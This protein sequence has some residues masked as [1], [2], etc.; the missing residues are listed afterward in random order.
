M[1][2]FRS[3]YQWQTKES[4]KA[5]HSCA[6]PACQENGEYKA[7]I[8]GVV[9]KYQYFCLMHIRQFNKDWNYFEGMSDGQVEREMERN[10]LGGQTWPMGL[11]NAAKR[12]NF[13]PEKIKDPFDLFADDE[14]ETKAPPH[15][16][17]HD[18]TDEENK[19]MALLQL[20]P[21]FDKTIL[22]NAYRKMVRRYHPDSIENEGDTDTIK[23]IN[24]AYDVLKKLLSRYEH[25]S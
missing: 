25:F 10:R 5:E 15:P 20:E 14:S 24:H 23:K 7:P 2:Y 11:H 9:G 22:R 16:L 6:Y 4:E 8:R 12:I 1:R 3:S 19:A 13:R 18:I 21:V 17:W